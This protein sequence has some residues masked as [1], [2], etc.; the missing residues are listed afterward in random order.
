MQ[1]KG[2]IHLSRRSMVCSASSL[3]LSGG[4]LTK[5]SATTAS[6]NDT[7]RGLTLRGA[8]PRVVAYQGGAALKDMLFSP[9]RAMDWIASQVSAVD[10]VAFHAVTYAVSADDMAAISKKAVAQSCYVALGVKTKKDSACGQVLVGPNGNVIAY[11]SCFELVTCKTDIGLIALTAGLNPNV[12]QVES[13]V[14]LVIHSADRRGICTHTGSYVVNLTADAC[15]GGSTI[16]SP[17]G[18]PI[19]RAGAGW[20]QGIVAT[21]DVAGLKRSREQEKKIY[22]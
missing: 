17:Y 18:A 8:K 4:I 15:G 16:Y 2:Q 22:T 1:A 6:A 7:A 21:I 3:M 5:Y 12:E 20:T 14:D 9:S 10:L 11:G 13:D 19:T